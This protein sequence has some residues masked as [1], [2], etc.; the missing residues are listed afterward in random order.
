ME[1]S[2]ISCAMPSSLT[3][4]EMAKTVRES[5]RLHADLSIEE[6]IIAA[7]AKMPREADFCNLT[8]GEKVSQLFF[9]ISLEFSP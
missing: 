2:I 3:L 5:L 6:T 1:S 4:D 7:S 8:E 9:D